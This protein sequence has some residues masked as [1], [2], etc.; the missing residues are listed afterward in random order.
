[1]WRSPSR[2]TSDRPSDPDN[3]DRSTLFLWNNKCNGGIVSQSIRGISPMKPF[4]LLALALI[5]TGCGGEQ[6]PEQFIDNSES[7]L[8]KIYSE[9]LECTGLKGQPFESLSIEFRTERWPCPMYES[10]CAGTFESPNKFVLINSTLFAHELIH[11][12]RWYNFGN[13]DP[14]HED[15]LFFQCADP[16][17]ITPLQADQS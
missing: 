8:R 3:A 9:T 14:G 10:G 2:G 6:S 11:Y 15:P 16:D 1:M 12:L 7:N 17:L 5:F 13:A 4:I